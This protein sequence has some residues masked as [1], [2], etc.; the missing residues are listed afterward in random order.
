MRLLEVCLKSILTIEKA[1][2]HL[3][4]PS[5]GP[6]ALCLLKTKSLAS[7]VHV[8]PRKTGADREATEDL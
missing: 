2:A 6:V 8:S 4:Q 5:S 3:L 7:V 1:E